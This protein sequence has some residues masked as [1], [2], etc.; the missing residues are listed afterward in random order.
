MPQALLHELGGQFE[1]AISATIDAPTGVE[2]PQG[3]HP[4]IF[5]LAIGVERVP[6]VPRSTDAGSCW[7]TSAIGGP[8]MPDTVPMKPDR[9]PAPL[10]LGEVICLW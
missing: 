7:Y 3:M 4:C 5:R 2:M 1:S 6:S 9:K 10:R 8:P